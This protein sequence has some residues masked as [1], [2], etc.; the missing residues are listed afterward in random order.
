MHILIT[1]AAGSGTS[2]LAAAIAAA[3]PARAIETDDYFWRPTTPPYQQKFGHEERRVALLKDLHAS[4][5]AVVAGAL[6]GWG[7][8]LEN[9]FGLVVF[10]YVPTAVRLARLNDREERRF[11]KADPEFLA[12]AA[13]Y[14]E[15]TAE[16]RSLARH[17]E[18]LASRK[19]PVLC[20]EGDDTIEARQ[21]AVLAARHSLLSSS[22]PLGNETFTNSQ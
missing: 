21:Q 11:G 10:L 8:T 16:G 3:I 18:W 12:W 6:M 17:R 14:D 5:N 2:T 20:L 7:E 19:C 4:P 13:Q 22:S 1:G 9:A 15:G